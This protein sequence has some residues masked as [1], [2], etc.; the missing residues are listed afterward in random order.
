MSLELL[1]INKTKTSWFAIVTNNLISKLSWPV[2]YTT[3]DSLYFYFYI[4]NNNV[5]TYSNK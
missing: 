3:R 1:E 4:P 2:C 5:L